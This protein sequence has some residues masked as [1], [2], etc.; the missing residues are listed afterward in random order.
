MIHKYILSLIIKMLL[1]CVGSDASLTDFQS[2]ESNQ[3]NSNA[4]DNT[5][6]GKT[7]K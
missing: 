6:P 5:S 2:T 3:H 7:L 4:D 1:F